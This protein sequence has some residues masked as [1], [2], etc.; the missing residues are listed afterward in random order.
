MKIKVCNNAD[1]TA[2]VTV[3][4]GE[5]A[6]VNSAVVDQGEEVVLTIPGASEPSDIELGEV[7]SST[8]AGEAGAGESSEPD[9]GASE[10]GGDAG[11]SGTTAGEGEAPGGEG[12]DAS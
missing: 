6:T 11:E 1:G 3:L 8:S 2:N 7:C 5:D 4:T 10:P 12:G 9:A